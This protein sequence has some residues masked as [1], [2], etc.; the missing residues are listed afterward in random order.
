MQF[1]IFTVFTLVV[2]AVA[3]PY[4]MVRRQD[5]KVPANS[6]A[7]TDQQGNVVPFDT[8]KVF[9]AAKAKGQ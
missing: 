1:S 6:A 7:M 9:H 4:A 5:S 8:N 2:A 3:H